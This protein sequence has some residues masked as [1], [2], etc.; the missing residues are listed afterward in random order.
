MEA[1]SIQPTLGILERFQHVTPTE[2]LVMRG[3]AIGI[4]AGLDEASLIARQETC[5]RWIVWDEP[6][7]RKGDDDGGQAFLY[8]L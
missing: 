5:C 6:I 1:Q 3:I 8:A 4:E 7:R 2:T